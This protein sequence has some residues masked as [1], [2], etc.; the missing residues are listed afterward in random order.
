MVGFGKEEIQ[1]FVKQSFPDDAGSGEQF[2]HQLK[3]H[4]HL[5]S[6]AYVPMN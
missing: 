3:E 5:E 2:M 6:L 4:P 1:E